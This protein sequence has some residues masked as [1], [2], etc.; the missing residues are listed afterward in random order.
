MAD[1]VTNAYSLPWEEVVGQW[2]AV[3]VTATEVLILACGRHPV[4]SCQLRV[5]PRCNPRHVA[6]K[7]RRKFT[8]TRAVFDSLT[9]QTYASRSIHRCCYAIP[10]VPLLLG[11][12]RQPSQ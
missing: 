12:T 4:R 1:R 9:P 10:P 8:R 6:A 11:H 3:P 7:L 5:Q 2:I